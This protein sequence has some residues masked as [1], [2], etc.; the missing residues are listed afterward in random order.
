MS[1][2]TEALMVSPLKN[3]KQWVTRREF[4]YDVGEEGSGDVVSVPIGFIT[5]FASV[6]RLFWTI[7]PKW[8]KYGN[9]AVIHDY[10]YM[11][12]ERSRKESDDIFYEG[13]VVL[14]T[15]KIIAKIMYYA[16]RIFG[17]FAYYKDNKRK[18]FFETSEEMVNVPFMDIKVN[19]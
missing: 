3:G 11:S 19:G 15:N 10:L 14:G 13:M 9:A 17:G 7:L 12:Q 16:V 2:F 18:Y 5:D 6:P 8:G 4:I 1:S